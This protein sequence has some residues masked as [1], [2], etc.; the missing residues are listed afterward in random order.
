MYEFNT[1]ASHPSVVLLCFV[2]NLLFV[3]T[4]EVMFPEWGRGKAGGKMSSFMSF[5]ALQLR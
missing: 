5:P 3:V 2:P 1:R 4:V